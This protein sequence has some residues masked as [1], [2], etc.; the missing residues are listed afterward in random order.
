MPDAVAE[1]AAQAQRATPRPGERLVRW[2]VVVT[3]VGMLLTGVAML[4]LVTSI[5]LPSGFWALA[6]VVG[7]GFAMIL[8]GLWRTGRARSRAQ[9]AARL[10]LA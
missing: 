8:A 6:M 1:P 7:V 10:D 2:G 3:V 9:R 5:E 4:P